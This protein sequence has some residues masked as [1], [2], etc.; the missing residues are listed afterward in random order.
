MKWLAGLIV[1]M[2]PVVAHAVPPPPGSPDA[3]ELQQFTAEEQA[4]IARQHDRLGH[5][6]CDRGDFAFI[7]IRDN[8][9]QLQAKAKHPDP[10]RHIPDGWLDVHDDKN[11]DLKGQTHFPDVVAAWYYQGKIQCIILGSG[12]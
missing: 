12:Y 9:G 10:A 7:D 6:C 2:M 11:V 1:A 8:N 3:L 5:W 4:W